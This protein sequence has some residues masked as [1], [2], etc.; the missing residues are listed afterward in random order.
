MKLEGRIA[1][2]LDEFML[3][4]GHL[5]VLAPILAKTSGNRSRVARQLGEVLTAGVIID[6][7]SLREVG[8]YLARKKLCVVIRPDGSQVAPHPKARY[9]HLT[10]ILGPDNYPLKIDSRQG[11]A[12]VWFQDHA[13]A[14]GETRSKVGAV[15]ADTTESS[16]KSGVSH[17][18]DWAVIIGLAN[19]R[20]GLT[21]IGRALSAVDRRLYVG[22]TGPMGNPYIIGWER[23]AFAWLQFMADGDVLVRLIDH[24]SRVDSLTKSDAMELAVAI[25]NEMRDEIGKG[26][27]GSVAAVRGAREFQRDL[28]ISPGSRRRATKILSTAWHRMA[29]RLESL[30]DIG[31]LEKLEPNGIPRQFDYYYRP[32]PALCA[33]A[34]SIGTSSTLVDWVETHLVS[35]LL[36]TTS[37]SPSKDTSVKQELIEALGTCL[38]PTGIHID[39]FAVVAATLAATGGK[40]L[41]LGEARRRLT[42]AAIERPEHVRL[43]RGYS[44][45]RAEFASVIGGRPEDVGESLFGS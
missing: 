38:G 12:T 24:L 23:I 16:N 19:R 25:A 42:N 37:V 31:L 33:A 13:I 11:V 8:E 10:A 9:S 1:L 6:A 29:S 26:S 20:L 5:K 27:G 44:G 7:G 40:V 45:S 30:T 32:T 4:L 14:S 43:S 34:Q 35:V 3:R 41:S 39:S 18:V 21:S 22:G 2:G 28:G 36:A 15:T 17:L